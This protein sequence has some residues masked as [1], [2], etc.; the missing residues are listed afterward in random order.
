MGFL[1]SRQIAKK[2][3]TDYTDFTDCGFATEEKEGHRGRKF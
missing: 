1:A 3:T 2:L